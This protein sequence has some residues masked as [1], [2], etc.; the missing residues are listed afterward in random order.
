ML[1]MYIA[2]S[3]P[4][5]RQILFCLRG[6]EPHRSTLL[7]EKHIIIKVE[8]KIKSTIS[9]QLTSKL[10]RELVVLVQR[11]SALSALCGPSVSAWTR[12]LTGLRRP[13]VGPS[14][15]D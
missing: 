14:G 15:G 8:I 6:L 11:L 13:Q 3:P 1:W 4:I 5:A 9:S 7:Q 10:Q 12:A 2:L